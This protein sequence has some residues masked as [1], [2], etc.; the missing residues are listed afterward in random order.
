MDGSQG[1]PEDGVGH[2]FNPFGTSPGLRFLLNPIQ[3]TAWAAGVLCTGFSIKLSDGTCRLTIR[4]IDP[5][6]KPKVAFITAH[7]YAECMEVWYEALHT[8]AYNLKWLDD[9]FA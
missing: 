2:H 6:G 3:E 8:T 1:Q 4:V 5:K 9:R 7:S